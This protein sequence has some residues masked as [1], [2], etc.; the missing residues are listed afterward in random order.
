MVALSLIAVAVIITTCGLGSYL[1]VRD[2]SKIVGAAPAP[3]DVVPKRDISSRAT[4]PAPLTLRDVFP[5][6]EIMA[7]DPSVPPYKRVGN[8]QIAKD[9]R[10]AATSDLGKLLIEL[11]C[12]QV[13]RATFRSPDGAYF[14]TAGIFNLKDNTSAAQAHTDIK[15]LVDASK[16]RFSGLV[17]H[18]SAKVLGRAPT[19]LAWD[20][21]GHFLI[22]SVIARAD[23][24][25]FPPDDPNVKV[26]VYDVV[27]KYLR[28][29]VIVEWSIDRS[30]PGP[31][32]SISATVRTTSS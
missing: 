2:D 7:A 30:T 17:S 1:L 18:S 29:H 3:S 6:A 19:N 26:I 27:E 20:S 8:A 9:C 14:L 22:Y 13:V 12:N 16:G 24:K 15:Q 31:S 25:D 21:Q 5:T 28:D 11:G 10:V 4:D 32:R 23:A